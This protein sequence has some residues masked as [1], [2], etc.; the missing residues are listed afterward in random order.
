M[1]YSAHV[2]DQSHDLFFKRQQSLGGPVLIQ[3]GSSQSPPASSEIMTS[4]PQGESL[5]PSYDQTDER[6]TLDN[7]LNQL[8]RVS[9]TH[10]TK[11]HD[12]G[13]IKSG[14]S[15]SQQQSNGFQEARR[16]FNQ[17]NQN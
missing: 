7:V 10:D 3:S 9:S 5:D 17:S 11:M 8:A 13:S 16:I 6:Q 4:F 2:R 1:V 14:M 12:R 15:N